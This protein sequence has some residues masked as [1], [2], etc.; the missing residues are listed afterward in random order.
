MANAEDVIKEFERGNDVW[1]HAFFFVM[2][3]I[4]VVVL[5]NAT[6]DTTVVVT[7]VITVFLIGNALPRSTPGV[8]T[9]TSLI[10]PI[11]LGFNVFSDIKTQRINE[12]ESL[13]KKQ[14]YILKGYING[15]YRFN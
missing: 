14:G 10:I 9:I 15:Y 11:A 3:V 8:V 13:L 1:V 12:T 5:Y 4:S 7:T 6:T 2:S